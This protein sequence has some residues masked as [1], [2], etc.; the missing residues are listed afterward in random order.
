M[1]CKAFLAQLHEALPTIRSLDATAVAVGGGFDFQ[2][3]SLRDAG[4]EVTILLDP[5][6]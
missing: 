5:P 6:P 2:A 4:N 1:P 3:R